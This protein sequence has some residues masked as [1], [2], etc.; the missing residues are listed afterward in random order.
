MN[1]TRVQT[2]AAGQFKCLG[3]EC[4][5]TCCAGWSMQLTGETI[6]QYEQH[7]PE[8]LNDV[9]ADESGFM[10]KRDAQ[11]SEC[12]KFE[13]GLCAIQR[14]YSED[15]LGDACYFFPRI[16][17]ALGASLLT[18]MTMACPEAARLMLYEPGAFT[19]S[20][21]TQVRTPYSLRNYLPQGIK[22]EV[23]LAIHTAFIDLANDERVS[24]AHS[25]MRSSAIVRALEMQPY[26]AW[27]GALEFYMVN[28]DSRIP[29]A[30][31]LATDLFNLCHAL[32]GLV[33]AS[34][35]H[36]ARL[37]GAID[38]MAQMLGIT[39]TPPGSI[40]LAD[41]AAERAVRVLA[42]MRKQSLLL[43]PVL[44]RYL[45]AQLSESCFPFAGLGHTLSERI[46]IIGVRYATIRLALATLGDVPAQVDVVRIIQTLSRFSDHLADP[47]LSLQIYRET[48]WSREP[49][50]KAIIGE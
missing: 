11:T 40:A 35:S 5:D 26:T 18:T 9:V 44:R 28:A 37:M 33:M 49:R 10:M 42:I 7:A 31:P 3:A 41:D 25:I 34:Q 1:P 17:R 48:G 2:R 39:F 50:L 15:L 47:S 19:L 45:Q 12:V 20:E 46:T 8:L 21:R 38:A 30:E 23:A 29:K 13:Q 32:H 36:G 22:E 27:A 43:Q 14:D 24:A 4:P 16:T 6:A